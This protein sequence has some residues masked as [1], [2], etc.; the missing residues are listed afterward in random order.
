MVQIHERTHFLYYLTVVECFLVFN[1]ISR[2][3]WYFTP[4][5]ERCF[6]SSNVILTSYH[7]LALSI[8]QQAVFRAHLFLSKR[9]II[10][11]DSKINLKLKFTLVKACWLFSV[12]LLDIS[13]SAWELNICLNTPNVTLRSMFSASFSDHSIA[14]T[15]KLF[16]A[17]FLYRKFWG[18]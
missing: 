14:H 6:S 17:G 15:L 5:V 10:L 12:F 9:W 8:F 3:Y 11:H 1:L 13:C 7:D 2:M 4:A 16:T 18:R